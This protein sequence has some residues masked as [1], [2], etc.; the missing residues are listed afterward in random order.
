MR[1]I[2]TNS[3]IDC[4]LSC[5]KRTF[6]RSRFGAQFT[7]AENDR[8]FNRMSALSGEFPVPFLGF[9]NSFVAVP[10][11]HQ[12]GGLG[13]SSKH[14]LRPK[15]ILGPDDL[16]QIHSPRSATSRNR[17]RLSLA[18]IYASNER[19]RNR[20]A[21]FP[22]L[23]F[24]S[25]RGQNRKNIVLV[26]HEG[27]IAICH[28]GVVSIHWSSKPTSTRSLPWNKAGVDGRTREARIKKGRSRRT[29]ANASLRASRL[30]DFS[31]LPYRSQRDEGYS[32]GDEHSRPDQFSAS[33]EV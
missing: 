29:M 8:V 22:F 1:A 11:L 6:E 19:P 25:S 14:L 2:L 31:R 18:S 10:H 4:P 9:P 7:L 23:V 12:A 27:R 16:A 26:D 24:S 28:A 33:D 30:C 17:S 32:D 15:T 21:L 13:F 3:S 5:C 20:H